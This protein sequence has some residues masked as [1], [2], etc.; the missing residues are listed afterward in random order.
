MKKISL[1]FSYNEAL[2]RRC[3]I[4]LGIF[5]MISGLV[6]MAYLGYY[7]RYWSDDWCYNVDFK[8]L[9]IVGTVNTYFKT[10]I[11]DLIGYGYSNNRYSLTLLSGLLFTAGITGAKITALLVIG[12][13]LT[14][15]LWLL[16]NL[17]NIFR[18]P[19]K[20]IF[21]LAATILL[22][23]TLYISPQRFQVLYWISGIHYSFSIITG[24]YL[25][26]LVTYQIIH[27]TRSRVVDYISF[28]LA[29]FAGGFSEIGCAYL[30]TGGGIALLAILYE[31]QRQRPWAIRAFPTLSLV[32][33]GLVGSFVALILSPS[34][35]VRLDFVSKETTPILLTFLMSFRFSIEFMIDS[36]RSTPFPHF[37]IVIAFFSLSILAST[38][39]LSPKRFLWKNIALMLAVVVVV[40]ILISALQAPTVYIYHTPPDPRGKS[41]ARFTMLAGLAVISW[42]IG[43][44]FDFRQQKKLIVV[45]ALLGVA[46]SIIYSA[47]S[48]TIVYTELPGFISRASLWDYRDTEIQKTREKGITKMEVIVI[49]MKDVGVK[50]IMQS[51]LMDKGWVSTCASRYYGLE[52]I[53]VFQP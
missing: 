43:Q 8:N 20:N 1:F 21:L 47:R 44:S 50:D 12:C 52:A 23:Y 32:F 45:F 28:P 48:M 30:I 29:F 18:Y 19:S 15:L 40:W 46:L 26:G 11:N 33:L 38:D 51:S 25:A 41:L 49:D 42:L 14:G 17:A 9:G 31:R 2:I 24:L 16:F 53:K 7:N 34:N 37:V 5:V 27:D 10:G 39:R 36:I 22:Y 35:T 4:C 6:L 13:W 3:V